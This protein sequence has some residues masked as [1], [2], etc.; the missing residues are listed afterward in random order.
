MNKYFLILLLFSQVTLSQNDKR[1]ALVIGNANYDK[2]ELKNPANDAKLI[3][4]TLDS[5]G[6]DVLLHT[7]I[8]RRRDFLAAINEFGTKLPNYDVS[9][10]YYA[11]HG[12][13]IN[14][15]NFLLPTKEIFEM[16]I[17]VEDY[18]VSVQRILKYIEAKEKEKINILVI[19]ACRD[20][21]FEQSWNNTRSLKGSGLAKLNPPTGS[22]IAFS[23]DSGNTAP[24]GDG[25]NSLYTS[26]LSRNLL[27]GGVSIEQ[28]FKYVREEVLDKSKGIQ[29]PIEN[30]TLIGDPYI[31]NKTELFNIEKKLSDLIL[32]SSKPLIDEELAQ[33]AMEL[34]NK[35]EHYNPK[36]SIALIAK[37]QLNIYDYDKF[38]NLYSEINPENI[39]IKFFNF[40]TYLKA[41]SIG[42]KQT[43]IEA[44]NDSIKIKKQLLEQQ[45]SIYKKLAKIDKTK[46]YFFNNKNAYIS[47]YWID[48]EAYRCAYQLGR[49]FK[50]YSRSIEMIE[51]YLYSFDTLYNNNINIFKSNPNNDLNAERFGRVNPTQYLLKFK[52]ETDYDKNMLSQEWIDFYKKYPNDVNLLGERIFRVMALN[53]NEL[54]RVLINKSIS[55][56]PTNPETY[57]MLYKIDKSNGD[58][59]SAILNITYAIERN[60]T[61][62]GYSIPSFV[63]NINRSFLIENYFN[64]ET[65]VSN[66]ELKLL[67]AELYELVGNNFQMCEEY[68]NLISEINDNK[69]LNKIKDL[70]KIKCL[71]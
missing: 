65:K 58:Y 54:A 21:P 25:E 11:G 9:F 48:E 39:D 57:F 14:S 35:I 64:S 6:F 12:I 27:K 46:I 17:D 45:I 36:S 18:G 31:I 49:D 20:N 13:Q 23:T 42:Y 38:M 52:E 8:E 30:N 66:I 60:E 40:I 7:N 3:A 22:I 44:S 29:K 70:I 4:S 34:V 59:L 26:A 51:N 5:I 24:D 53:E 50:E 55:L 37:L 33:E 71:K 10:V 67:R 68:N 2:G 32:S 61:E 69:I 41:R 16:E 43:S 1:L 56:D 28:V 19:D 63:L 47:W 15:E 62:S